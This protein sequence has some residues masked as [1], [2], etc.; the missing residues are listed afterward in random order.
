MCWF[1]WDVLYLL[2]HWNT[3]SKMAMLL[4]RIRRCCRVRGMS[5]SGL[6]KCKDVSFFDSYL[7]FVVRIQTLSPQLPGPASMPAAWWHTSPLWCS[8]CSGTWP[9][10]T[11]PSISA[12]AV[13]FYYNYR[14]LTM[15]TVYISPAYCK[16]WMRANK[17]RST[18][19]LAWIKMVTDDMSGCPDTSH[20]TA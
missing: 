6:C 13:L 10:Q 9:K 17:D 14:M 3:W 15:R 12:L 16:N 18:Q 2:G 8:P 19:W 4:V 1:K 20:T 5:R 11:P 7:C